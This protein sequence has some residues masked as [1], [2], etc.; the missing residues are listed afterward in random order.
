MEKQDALSILSS[1]KTI[2]GPG[3]Y[4]ARVTSVTPYERDFERGP[5]QIAIVNINIMTP[6]H[7]EKAI[8]LFKQGLYQESVN[9][10]LT[11]S[12]REGE[13]IPTKGETVNVMVS[14]VTTN[15][16]V[17]GLFVTAVTAIP[18]SAPSSFDIS[19]LE[20]DETE[21]ISILVEEPEIVDTTNTV[22]KPF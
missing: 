5:K 1:R 22:K 2:K 19:L 8:M 13:F 12:I 18:A 21:G 4:T 10:N 16:G 7:T 6:F 14:E 20:E 15:N 3:K 11:A 17:T 9:Q